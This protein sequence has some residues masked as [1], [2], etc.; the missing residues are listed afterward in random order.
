MASIS[1]DGN[2]AIVGVIMDGAWLFRRAAGT[3]IQFGSQ[4]YG[5]G[6]IDK[7][8]RIGGAYQGNA[9]AISADATTVILGGWG[10]NGHITAYVGVGAAW[11]FKCLRPHPPCRACHLGLRKWRPDTQRIVRFF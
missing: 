3:W 5:T 4:L 1:G 7:P 8:V 10:D 11:V 2:T 6:E 9:L